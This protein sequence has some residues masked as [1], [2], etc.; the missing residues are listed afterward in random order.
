M[1]RIGIVGGIGPESTI[2]Y[3]RLFMA[4]GHTD[5]TIDSVDVQQ[6]LAWMQRA[7]LD[8]VADYLAAAVGRLAAGGAE[9]ALLAANTPHIVFDRV[10]SRAPI[11]MVSI[12]AAAC[13]H[14]AGLGMQRAAL[15]GTRYTMEGQFYPE[16]FAR[17]GVALVVPPEP[18]RSLVHDRY[19]NELLKNILRDETRQELLGVVERLVA[20]EGVQAVILGGTELPLIL[21]GES[22]AGAALVDTTR[23][24]AQAVLDWVRDHDR[25]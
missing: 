20:R 9:V 15:L 8:P 13:A 22:H 10:A 18:D 25:A 3:Y 17:R 2:E 24:H 23:V 4:A 21:K 16:V 7:Q 11:P 6:L 14:V 19:L 5:V 12:V 1:K